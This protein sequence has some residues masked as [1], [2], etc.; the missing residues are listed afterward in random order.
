MEEQVTKN[1]TVLIH[2]ACP[3]LSFPHDISELIQTSLFI[4]KV[5]NLLHR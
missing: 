1:D 2:Y 5:N 4:I 3:H